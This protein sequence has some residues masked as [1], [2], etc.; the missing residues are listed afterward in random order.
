[1]MKTQKQRQSTHLA[2]DKSKSIHI[3]DAV[4]D[5]MSQSIALWNT[6]MLDMQD[7]TSLDVDRLSSANPIDESIS[8][9]T[10]NMLLESRSSSQATSYSQSKYTTTFQPK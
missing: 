6:M 7:Q 9:S 4:S 2:V 8:S 1:M 5:K 10:P 3:K